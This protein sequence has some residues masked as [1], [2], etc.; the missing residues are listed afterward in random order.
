L[1]H[2]IPRT[3]KLEPRA[4]IGYLVGY[5]STN[6]F[7]IW[8]PSRN[9][10]IKTRDVTFNETLFYDPN[11]KDLA[12]LLRQPADQIVEVG[13]LIHCTYHYRARGS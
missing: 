12:E 4:H 13:Y 6:I 8:V 3:Q 5:E 9:E 2:D 7:R 1:I 11:I 10:V